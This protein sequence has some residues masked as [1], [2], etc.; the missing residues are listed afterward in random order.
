MIYLKERLVR[1][2]GPKRGHSEGNR[3]HEGGWGDRPEKKIGV[4][5]MELGKLFR[6]LARGWLGTQTSK[7]GW[8]GM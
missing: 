5:G 8:L 7:D 1:E 2:Q 4:L 6:K 3:R